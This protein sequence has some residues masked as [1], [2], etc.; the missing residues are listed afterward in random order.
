ML[1]G[2]LAFFGNYA[3]LTNIMLTYFYTFYLDCTLFVYIGFIYEIIYLLFIRRILCAYLYVMSK[4]L[5]LG[6]A[7]KF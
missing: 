1:T 5:G 2:D 7:F 4:F 3:L 6:F